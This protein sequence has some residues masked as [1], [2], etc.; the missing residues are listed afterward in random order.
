MG[1]RL[2]RTKELLDAAI[3]IQRVLVIRHVSPDEGIPPPRVHL[4]GRR[5]YYL[6]K[7]AMK[8]ERDSWWSGFF[9]KS[10]ISCKPEEI[11]TESISLLLPIRNASSAPMLLSISLER[12]QAESNY[13]QEA[14]HMNELSLIISTTNIFH[15]IICTLAAL[16]AGAIPLIVSF[17]ELSLSFN[18]G[19][20]K[21]YQLPLKQLPSL[22]DFGNK[23]I[24]IRHY[25]SNKAVDSRRRSQCIAGIQTVYN[26]LGFENP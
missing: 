3:A 25:F 13:V 14:L 11:P 10:S 23:A 20:N 17:A 16:K 8:Q 12:F 19:K 15:Q 1:T 21:K 24:K 22:I 18:S 26:L 6:Y 4:T 2:I 5:P 9:P 7:I